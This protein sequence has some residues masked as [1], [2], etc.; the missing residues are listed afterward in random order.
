[1]EENKIFFP[2]LDNCMIMHLPSPNASYLHFLSLDLKNTT[3]IEIKMKTWVIP[4]QNATCL[5]S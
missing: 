5:S 3:H 2:S 1:M 4:D